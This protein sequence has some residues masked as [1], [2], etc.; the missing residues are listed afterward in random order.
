MRRAEVKMTA[1]MV[2][3]NVPLAFADHLSPLL[4][5]IFPDSEIA[6]VYNSAKTKTTCILNGALRP[7]YLGELIAEMKLGPF[8]L[9]IDGSNNTGLKKMNPM[10]V[11]VFSN[12][13]VEHKFLDM[14]TTSGQR[15]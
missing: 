7:F 3:H 12:S 6:K 11:H 5:D 9:S 4:R 14:C 10:T 1:T 8:S 2:K 13:R 15:V